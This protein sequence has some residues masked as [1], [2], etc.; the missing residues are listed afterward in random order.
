[1]QL[2]GMIL[3]HLG[4][5]AIASHWY[6]KQKTPLAEVSGAILTGRVN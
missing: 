5:K 2:M 3:P 4:E 1:M 6:T